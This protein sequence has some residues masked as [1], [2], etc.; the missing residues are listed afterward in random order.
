MKRVCCGVQL[1]GRVGFSTE[2]AWGWRKLTDVFQ[3]SSLMCDMGMRLL[4]GQGD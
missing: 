4:G 3:L 1:P 2:G